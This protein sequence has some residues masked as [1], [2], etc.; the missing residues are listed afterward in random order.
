[1]TV[2]EN[3]VT[4]K[5]RDAMFVRAPRVPLPVQASARS[6]EGTAKESFVSSALPLG[7]RSLDAASR[8]KATLAN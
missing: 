5:K 4:L 3:R 8:W 6:P 2:N 7:D 1:M